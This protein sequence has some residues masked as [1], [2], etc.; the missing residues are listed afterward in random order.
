[1][2]SQGARLADNAAAQKV[3]PP[4]LEIP[5]MEVRRPAARPHKLKPRDMNVLTPS[6]F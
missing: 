1:M 4:K 2:K 5:A 3:N 6:G